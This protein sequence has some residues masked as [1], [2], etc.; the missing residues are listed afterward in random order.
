MSPHHNEIN[1]KKKLQI[2]LTLTA[3]SHFSPPKSKMSINFWF[4]FCVLGTAQFTRSSGA[5]LLKFYC[6][7]LHTVQHSRISTEV[8]MNL[9]IKTSMICILNRTGIIPV[10]FEGIIKSYLIGLD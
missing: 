9:E 1:H 8:Q 2:E 5:P 3:R 7:V 10:C 4:L 6:L